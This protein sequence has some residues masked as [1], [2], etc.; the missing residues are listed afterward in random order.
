MVFKKKQ[1]LAVA[2]VLVICTGVFLNWRYNASLA[3]NADGD[4]QYEADKVLGETEL[5][6]NSVTKDYFAGD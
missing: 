4:E 1:V 6:N 2:M 5:V 3:T